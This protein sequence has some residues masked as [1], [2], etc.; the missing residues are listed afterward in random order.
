MAKAARSFN[1]ISRRDFLG[2]ASM[3]FLAS[4][5]GCQYPPRPAVSVVR[6]NSGDIDRAVR[7]AIDLLGG[8]AKITRNKNHICVKPNL[9]GDSPHNTT[10]PEV[11]RSLVAMMKEAGKDVFIGEGSAV[12][13]SYSQDEFGNYCY[14]KDTERLDAMQREVFDTLGYT[15]MAEAL[16]VDL[17][18]LHTGDMVEVDV[19]KPLAFKK[20]SINKRLTEID[21]LCSVPMMKT[22]YFAGVTLGLKNL[23]GLYPGS[24]Y[25][26][27]RSVIHDDALARNSPGLAYEIIDMVQ[28][29]KLGLVVIDAT[30]AMEG[31]GPANGHVFPMGII[32]AGTNPLATDIVA[33]HIMQ[34]SPEEIPHFVV[35]NEIGMTPS[36]FDQVEIFKSPSLNL[37]EICPDF[38]PAN[39]IEWN[40]VT[41]LCPPV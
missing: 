21:L 41:R 38:Q 29:N 14:L 30:N 18:N 12:S 20:L 33:A 28:V 34:I 25:G 32:I 7:K 13:T 4:L 9:V 5:I 19:P 17:V 22:H 10:N 15:A 27:L 3:T 24:V 40:Q 31:D 16:D 11:V 37:E 1:K 39:V 8:M 36:R 6:V 35:A 26:S 2:L 23:I